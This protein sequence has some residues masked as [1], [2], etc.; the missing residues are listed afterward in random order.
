MKV[1]DQ[2]IHARSTVAVT[3]MGL[4][5]AQMGSLYRVTRYAESASAFQAAWDAGIR[6]Y[7]TAPFYGFTR[8]ELRLGTMLT[9]HPRASYAI[10]TKVGRVMTPDPSVG[11]LEDGYAEPLPFRPVFDYTHDG[12]LRS[13]EA[14]QKR[15]GILAP[16]MLYV[17][18]IGRVTHGE[19]HAHYWSQLTQGGGFRA[20]TGLREQ[21]AIKAFGLGVNEC[22]IIAEAIEVADL[23]ICMLAGRYT[24][25]EQASLSFMDACAARG[26]GIVMAGAFNSGILAGSNKFNYGDAPADIV[27][28]VEALRAA[29]AVEGVTLQAA[30]LQF[31]LAHPAALTVVSGARNGEQITANIGWFEEPIPATFWTRLKERGLIADS[32]PVPV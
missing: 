14:S 3:A 25:L 23:D 15:L 31:P 2:R 12:I 16:D 10:S 29:C 5:C 13:F 30:A 27:A 9:E 18:D 21:G 11:A 6:Y 28:R 20:L 24:L 8:S 17:H 22:E 4:G 19:R 7:D 26:I 1:G 32:A